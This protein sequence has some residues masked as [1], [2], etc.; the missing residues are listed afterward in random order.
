MHRVAEYYESHSY[1]VISVAFTGRAA[2]HMP[3]YRPTTIARSVGMKLGVQSFVPSPIPDERGKRLS[4]DSIPLDRIDSRWGARRLL[5]LVDEISQLASEDAHLF[6]YI[7]NRYRNVV[8]QHDCDPV[9][10]LAGD[11]GQLQPIGGSLPHLFPCSF[12]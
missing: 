6:L 8:G 10:F 11:L 1:E 4:A 3:G 7:V 9:W 2:T 12:F 5:V